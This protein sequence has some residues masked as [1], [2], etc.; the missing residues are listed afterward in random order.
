M[1]NIFNDKVTGKKA[2]VCIMTAKGDVQ[3]N[4]AICNG[5]AVC[6]SRSSVKPIQDI[7]GQKIHSGTPSSQ[8]GRPA[9]SGAGLRELYAGESCGISPA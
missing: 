4:L 9:G 2:F 1:A 7:A 6:A 3:Q 8:S 5:N